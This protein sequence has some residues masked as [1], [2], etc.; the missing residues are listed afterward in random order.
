MGSKARLSKDLVPIINNVIEKYNVKNYIEPFVGGANV[1]DKVECE[2]KV[3]YDKHK[4]LIAFL[5]KI[6]EGYNPP[7]KVTPEH[8]KEVKQSFFD[9]DE[10]YDDYY[11]GTIGFLAAFRGLFFDSVGC[12]DY[13]SG[14]RVR[15]QL[16]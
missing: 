6:K 16:R 1:I 5:N 12:K 4:Y 7:E 11:Y 14:G 15:K 10:K 3:G 8:Y 13:V 9:K 2:N